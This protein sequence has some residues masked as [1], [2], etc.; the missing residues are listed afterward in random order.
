MNRER[1]LE[2]V[3]ASTFIN[4]NTAFLG[5][6]LCNLKF[7]WDSSIETACVSNTDFRWN[8]E[9]F[10]SLTKDERKFVLLHELWHIALLH[11]AR[12]GSRDPERWNVAC[13]IYINNNLI[14]EG[15]E[16]IKGCLWDAQYVDHTVTEEYIYDQLP[17]NQ[18]LQV[19]GTQIQKESS[20]ET[21]QKVSMVQQAVSTAALAGNEVGEEVI[22]V[23]RQFLKPKLPWRNLLH[24][25]LLEKKEPAWNWSHSNRRRRDVYLPAFLPQEESLTSILMCLDT[26]G[27]ISEEEIKRFVSEVKFVQTNL[28]PKKL[29]IIQFDRVIQE[30]KV[31][32]PNKPFKNIQ[33]KGHGGTSYK[34]VR[35]YIVQ[36]KPTLSIIFTDLFADPMIPIKQKVLWVVSSYKNP[37]FGDCIHVDE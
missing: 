17:P 35:E 30:I 14:S 2:Q 15:Y 12:M 4:Q 24:R 7:S 21:L 22:G 6:L 3:K 25:Y 26:S 1:Q 13:D 34:E 11:G 36:H 23:I 19:W 32:T 18:K 29:T 8:P 37:Q 27:S 28:N 20:S 31:Y 5:C 16:P 33:V 10:D 9:W